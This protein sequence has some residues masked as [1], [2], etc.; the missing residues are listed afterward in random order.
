MENYV[1]Q[2]ISLIRESTS[3]KEIKEKLS[4][5]HKSDI[6]DAL[7]LLDDNEKNKLMFI[8]GKEDFSEV[9]TYFDDA[10]EFIE[11][12]S[13]ESAADLVELMDA[14]DAVDMLQEL[15]EEDREHIISLMDEE[16]KEEVKLILSFD[17]DEIGSKMT[18]NFITI[19]NN[20]TIKKAM[21]KLIAQAQEND[22]ITTLIVTDENNKFFGV[23]DLKDL[24]CAHKDVILS[25]IIKVNYPYIYGK[26]KI[27][28]CI[29]EIRDY[30]EDI[31]PILN[32][33]EEVLGVITSNDI[34]EVVEEDL[35]DDFHKF[36]SISE[37][38]DLK[39]GVFTSIR[40]RIPWLTLL[41]FLGLTVS[42]LI[43]SFER[44]IETL[45]VMVFFQSLILG[46]AGNV[47][48]QS[49]AVTVRALSEEITFKEKIKL[50]FRE[51]RVGFLNGFFLGLISLVVCMIYLLITKTVIHKGTDNFIDT[52]VASSIVGLSL[53]CS[54]TLSSLSGTI[55]PMVF[56][57]IHI[58]P[59]VASGP[60]ITTINDVIAVICYY[61]LTLLLFSAYV[62]N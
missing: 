54:M 28:E 14:D 17:E 9:L 3:D 5:Y 58:D 25:D 32:E 40:K 59:A 36:A 2:I 24:I 18:T 52:L 19:L 31:I 22:N 61:G 62:L 29:N 35:S 46:M 7:D 8:L 51:F 45:P 38:N 21:R 37:D 12:V 16:A 4:T 57:K 55:I 47:G 34:T 49:L 23:I 48:T 43:S 15:D 39:E 20:D 53:L 60:L 27:D 33:N 42:I 41:V 30:D 56:K 13:Y 10:D 44:V 11:N 26:T 1:E 6:A 50:I